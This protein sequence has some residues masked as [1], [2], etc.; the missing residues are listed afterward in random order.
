[1]IQTRHYKLAELAN[2]ELESIARALTRGA[3]AVLA[4]DTVY[5]IG[6]GA[7]CEDAV[8]RICLLKNR[9]AAQPFQLLLPDIQTAFKLAVF[10]PKAQRLACAYW[11]GALTLILPPSTEGKPLLRGAQ[12]LGLRVPAFEPLRRLLRAMDT[13][14]ICT[15]ANLHGQPVITDETTVAAQ[16]QGK[17][18][19]ILTAGVLSPIASSVVDFVQHPPRLLREGKITKIELARTSGVTL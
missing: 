12:G 2:A 11:P 3:V 13:A 16:F 18:D 19:F 7:F 9:P 15:S 14:L 4:T 17:V 1:M 6:T 8:R 10:S 5:G